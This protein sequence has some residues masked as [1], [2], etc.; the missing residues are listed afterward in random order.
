VAKAQQPEKVAR[1]GILNNTTASGMAVLIDAFRQ[2]LSKLGWIEGKNFTI[3][4]R[5]GEQ[6]SERMPDLAAELVRLKVD[7]VVVASTPVALAVKKATTTIPIVMANV[8][9]PVGVNLVGSLARPGTNVTGNAGLS[10]RLKRL[11]NV[12]PKLVRVGFL[13]PSGGGAGTDL[14]LKEGLYIVNGEL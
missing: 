12:I 4:Y 8:G 13:R 14:Q 6:K 2:K 5:F 7:L 11:K 9:D 10:P 3:E 1:I